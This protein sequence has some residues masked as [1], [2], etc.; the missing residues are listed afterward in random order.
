MDHDYPPGDLQRQTQR[1]K[2]VG[3]RQI[4]NDSRKK[5]VTGRLT[6]NDTDQKIEEQTHQKKENPQTVPI[7]TWS[8]NIFQTILLFT[9]F[10]KKLSLGN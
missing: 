5:T 9:L 7:V 2:P 1:L 10:Y 6:D 4:G 8:D 3:N